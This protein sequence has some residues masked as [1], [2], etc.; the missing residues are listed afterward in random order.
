MSH[1]SRKFVTL[2][3]LKVPSGCIQKRSSTLIFFI[4]FED[5][6]ISCLQILRR[7]QART[8]RGLHLGQRR[9]MEQQQQQQQQQQ[10]PPPSR[11][12]LQRVSP[13]LL[14]LL[15]AKL[16]LP[17]RGLRE[18]PRQKG[19]GLQRGGRPRLPQGLH[20]HLRQDHLR[21]GTG[22]RSGDAQRR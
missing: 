12:P 17:H 16:L 13:A 15:P 14:L 7:G 9:R 11:L 21:Q 19:T 18:G 4:R 1:F 3:S 6:C 20:G 22:S 2:L 5:F 10:Q 8:H